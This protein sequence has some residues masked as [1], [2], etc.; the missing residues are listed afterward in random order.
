MEVPSDSAVHL[1]HDHDDDDADEYAP[2]IPPLMLSPEQLSTPHFLGA[3]GN[4]GVYPIPTGPS[5]MEDD[6]DEEGSPIS[7]RGS[8]FDGDYFAFSLS[9][10]NISTHSTSPQNR[11]IHPISITEVSPSTSLLRC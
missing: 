2:F 9:E 11:S 3:S 5:T 10:K 7:R 6:E 4:L 1:H 8:C